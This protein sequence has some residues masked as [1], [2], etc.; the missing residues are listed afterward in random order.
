MYTV[1][2]M[3]DLKIRRTNNRANGVKVL[4]SFEGYLRVKAKWSKSST[5][6]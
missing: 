3:E 6:F 2:E 4:R 5:E 1:T